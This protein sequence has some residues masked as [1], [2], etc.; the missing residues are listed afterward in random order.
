M[1]Y[2][3]TLLHRP[4]ISSGAGSSNKSDGSSPAGPNARS[5]LKNEQEKAAHSKDPTTG[6]NKERMLEKGSI[7]YVLAHD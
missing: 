6:L 4:G 1:L 2:S 5:M 3:L 7:K